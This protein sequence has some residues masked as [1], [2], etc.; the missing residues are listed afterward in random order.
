MYKMLVNLAEKNLQFGLTDDMKLTRRCYF[1]MDEFGNLP[2]LHRFDDIATIARSRE[3]FFIC[4]LQSYSQLDTVYGKDAAIKILAQLQIKIFIGTDDSKTIQAFSALCGKKKIISKSASVSL[5]KDTSDSYS[6]K[7]QPLISEQKLQL[8]C[9]GQ[10]GNIVVSSLG[11]F[12]ILSQF[13]PAY[14]AKSVYSLGNYIEQN[15]REVELFDET[16]TYIDISKKE[17]FRNLKD[18][19][20]FQRMMDLDFEDKKEMRTDRKESRREFE[21]RRPDFKKDLEEENSKKEKTEYELEIENVETKLNNL[22]DRK[23]VEM[24]TLKKFLPE[25][26]YEVI[27]DAPFDKAKDLIENLLEKDDSLLGLIRLELSSMVGIIDKIIDVKENYVNLLK[28]V[29]A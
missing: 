4:V 17:S 27:K 21:S 16:A 15:I 12:P 26:L 10:N 8:L 1:I 28:G 22:L 3:I 23:E 14:K 18:A 5:N 11:N 13:T 9:K 25:D 2:K 19:S 29:V 6:A 20:E 7:E 24:Q